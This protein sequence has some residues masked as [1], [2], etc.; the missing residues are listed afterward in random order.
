M[1][2]SMFRGLDQTNPKDVALSKALELL[3]QLFNN[4]TEFNKTELKSISLIQN[5]RYMKDMLTFFLQNKKHLKRKY[6][7]EILKAFEMCSRDYNP[8]KSLID[9]MFKRNEYR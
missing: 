7:K 1:P 9:K 3:T 8:N 2:E 5:D 6:S 4:I